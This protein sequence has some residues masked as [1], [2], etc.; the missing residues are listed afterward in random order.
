MWIRWIRIRNTVCKYIF[1][2]FRTTTT[3]T[4]NVQDV[5]VSSFNN[6][7]G[8]ETFSAAVDS[9]TT[10]NIAA[11]SE[12]APTS[13][14]EIPTPT[15]KLEETTAPSAIVAVAATTLTSSEAGPAVASAVR[16]GRRF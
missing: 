1:P 7:R 11:T 3:A 10:N 15:T 13:D 8:T 16:T 6:N 5:E 12:S 2:F 4:A 9:S 14:S